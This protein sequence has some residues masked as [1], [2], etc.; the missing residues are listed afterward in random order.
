MSLEDVLDGLDRVKPLRAG[1]LRAL[2]ERA[3]DVAELLEVTAGLASTLE[4]APEMADALADL[5]EH[6]DT[7]F[8]LVALADL[9]D[10]VERLGLALRGVS[11]HRD[12]LEWAIDQASTAVHP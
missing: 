3:E 8:R 7:V 1:P 6:S 10:D 11:R 12:E 2:A 5:E 9:A 4:A